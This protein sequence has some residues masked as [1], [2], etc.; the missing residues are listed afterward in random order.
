M[1]GVS[2]FL[3]GILHEVTIGI[4]EYVTNNKRLNFLEEKY[5]P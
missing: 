1:T 2:S 5:S 4:K 3:L